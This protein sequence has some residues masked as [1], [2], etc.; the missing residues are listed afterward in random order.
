MAQPIVIYIPIL[1]K[2]HLPCQQVSNHMNMPLAADANHDG[3]TARILD[4]F[5]TI[6]SDSACR[7]AYRSIMRYDRETSFM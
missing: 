4:V 6:M 1:V 3:T 7:V 2:Q 5:H